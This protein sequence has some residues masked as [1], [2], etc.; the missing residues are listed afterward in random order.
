MKIKNKLPKALFATVIAAGL[1]FSVTSCHKDSSSSTN[2]T[3]TEADAAQVTTDAVSPSTGGMASQVSSS[4]SLF[5]SATVTG[6]TVTSVNNHLTT[7]GTLTCGTEKDST[8][9][10][11]STGTTAPSY[12]YSLM[13]KYTLACTV[14][15]SLTLNFNGSG[16]YNG[17]VYS[18]SFTSTGGFVLTGLGSTATSFTFGSTYTRTGTTTSKVGNQY[19]F[20]H[21]LS[22]TSSNIMYDKTTD[23]ITSGT[24]TVSVKVTSSSGNSWTYGGM[25]TFLGNKT[26]KLVLNS[27]TVYNFSWT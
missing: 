20:N 16:S 25:L 15:S 6:G 12:T 13:W 27:G 26:A 14:P 5:T 3:I 21:T 7:Y 8:I 10:Y 9:A 17:L 24:A 1:A 4:A 11:A 19:T 23:E 2:D 22:I 18:T